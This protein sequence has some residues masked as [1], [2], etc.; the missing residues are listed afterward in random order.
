MIFTDQIWFSDINH[1]FS[2]RNSL[3]DVDFFLTVKCSNLKSSN[4][5]KA[6]QGSFTTVK[7]N[8]SCVSYIPNT[9]TRTHKWTYIAMVQNSRNHCKLSECYIM[10]LQVYTCDIMYRSFFR[11]GKITHTITMML[12][13]V[14][15]NSAM[16]FL[17][18]LPPIPW[19]YM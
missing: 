17:P 18:T 2:E 16:F 11:R 8:H 9:H 15:S 10:S 7:R 3:Y 5:S 4:S 14:L 19:E 1:A 13:K 6:V 12:T